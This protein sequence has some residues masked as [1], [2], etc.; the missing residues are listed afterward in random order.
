MDYRQPIRCCRCCSVGPDNSSHRRRTRVCLFQ[1]DV[2]PYLRIYLPFS[3]NFHDNFLGYVDVY[4]W[5]GSTYP[6]ST[7]SFML[8]NATPISQS[9]SWSSTIATAAVRWILM[10][11]SKQNVFCVIS[12]KS[13]PRSFLFSIELLSWFRHFMLARILMTKVTLFQYS[14]SLNSSS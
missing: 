5:P 9:Y 6:D 12:C 10:Y 2:S 4:T 11:R 7:S 13:Q 3:D 14:C 8:G 1:Q